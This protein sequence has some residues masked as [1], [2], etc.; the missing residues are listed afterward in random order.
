MKCDIGSTEYKV[1]HSQI[2]ELPMDKINLTQ[3]PNIFTCYR[4]L[5]FSTRPKISEQTIIPKI[6]IHL[7]NVSIDKDHLD[8]FNQLCGIQQQEIFITYPYTLSGSL[9]L[10][11]FAQPNFPL[12]AAGLLHLRNKIKQVE[13]ISLDDKLDIAVF[14]GDYRFRPQ[15]FEFDIHTEISTKDHLV[16]H[17]KSIFLKKGH[18]NKEDIADKDEDLFTKLENLEQPTATFKIP[19]NIGKRYA[20]ICQD[21]NPIHISNILAKVFGYKRSIAHGMWVLTRAAAELVHDDKITELNAVFKGPS[22][23]K[24]QA[25]IIKSDEHFNI[26]CGKNPRPVILATVK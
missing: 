10:T 25:S 14:T 24:S 26:F 13:T 23:S 8:Q 5:L 20:K 18:F 7:N 11:L 19:H 16:W 2:R 12:K 15:G 4:K 9:M 1:Y 6:A 17:S 3:S 21:Y 22:F